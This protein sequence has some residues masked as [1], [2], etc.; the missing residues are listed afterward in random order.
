[1]TKSSHHWGA[2]SQGPGATKTRS[3]FQV[4]VFLEYSNLNG[5]AINDAARGI[6]TPGL[7]LPGA[8]VLPLRQVTRVYAGLPRL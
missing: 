6:R 4:S 2:P 3:C 7:S 8:G 1:M 5:L